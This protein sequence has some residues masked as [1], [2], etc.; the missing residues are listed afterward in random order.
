M[1]RQA[2]GSSDIS[3]HTSPHVMSESPTPVQDQRCQSRPSARNSV[4]RIEGG[5]F[6]NYG[7]EP[8][9]TADFRSSFL[10]NSP[11]PATFPCWKI[12]FRTEVCICS[13]F[14]TETM[15]WIKE[16]ELR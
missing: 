11:R 1:G 9:T 6:E 5:F 14:S 3:E 15:L 2:F 7:A 13:Q 8:T 16:V 10:T 4:I 12:K